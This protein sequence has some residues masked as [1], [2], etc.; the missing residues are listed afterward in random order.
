MNGDVEE[1]LRE[2]LDRLTAEARVPAGMAGRTRAA[3]RRKKIA[4]RAALACGTA[5]VTATAVIAVTGPGTGPGTGGVTNAQT[6]AYVIGQV[7][8]ALAAENFVIQGQATGTDTFSVHG[9]RVRYSNEPTSSWTYRNRWRMEEFTGNSCGHALPNGVC[10]NRGG[11]EPYI[12][13]G[14]ALIGGRLVSAYLTYYDHRYSLSPLGHFHLKA[15]SRTAQLALGG[16]AVT[17]PNWPVFIKAMLGCQ[18]ATVTGHARIGGVQTTVISGLIDIPLSKGYAS[19][20]K[21]ARVRVRYALYVDSATYLPVRVYGSTQTYG[22]AAGPTDNAYVTQVRWLPP[23]KA[24][25][26][27]ALVTIPPGYQQ[28]SSPASQ[29]P[30]GTAS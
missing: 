6:T 21:E 17:I 29:Q 10:T 12:A 16:P 20:V 28:V 9:H 5:A 25:I 2:G 3:R 14:T 1:L 18:A 15:C 23:T 8:H 22:G 13:Q 4:A 24:N 7:Q 19:M 27:K 11:S 26:A 30:G